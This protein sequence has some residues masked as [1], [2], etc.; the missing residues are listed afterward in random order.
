MTP[1]N[2]SD[3]A[4]TP[5]T[6]SAAHRAGRMIAGSALRPAAAT[7]IPPLSRRLLS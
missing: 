6:P 1:I 2:S 7:G 3:A 4:A 5:V